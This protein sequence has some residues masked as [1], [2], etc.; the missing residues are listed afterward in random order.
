MSEITQNL[1]FILVAGIIVAGIFFFTGRAKKQKEAAFAKMAAEQ[2]WMYQSLNDRLTRGF[3]LQA[4]NWTF[5]TLAKFADREAGPGSVN[6]S[7]QTRWW[8]GEKSLPGRLA[9]IGPRTSAGNMN[10]PGAAM[11]MQ[12]AL[13]MMLGDQSS[14]AAGLSEVQ[15]GSDALRQRYMIMAH[16]PADMSNLLSDALERALLGWPAGSLPVIKQSPNGLLIEINNFEAKK[17][18]DVQ[19]V[20]NL[21]KILQIR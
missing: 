10:I 16:D 20:I 17:P 2:G 19:A 1:I 12:M 3:R 21:G 9:F 4:S 5:E 15:T 8:T 6:V 18:S 14:L 11:L 7:Y 13:P